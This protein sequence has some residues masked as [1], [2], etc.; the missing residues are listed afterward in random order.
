MTSTSMPTMCLKLVSEK[1]PAH[2]S[3]C[4]LPEDVATTATTLGVDFTNASDPLDGIC[5]RKRPYSP[6]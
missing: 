2:I 5:L 6:L 1:G 3:E 4:P